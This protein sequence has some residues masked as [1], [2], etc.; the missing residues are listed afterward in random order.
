MPKHPNFPA[1]TA[2]IIHFIF[3]WL[4][5]FTGVWLY[6][7]QTR[8]NHSPKASL[9]VLIGC[10]LG[11]GIGNK[12]L[13]IIEVPQSFTT[14][15]WTALLM[16]QTIVGGLLGGLIGVEIAKKILNIKQSTGDNFVFPLVVAIIIGRMGCFLAGLH[17]GTYGVATTLPW[18]VDFGDGI[19]RHPTQI[20]EQLFIIS[21]MLILW[22]FKPQL[23][24]VSGLQFK[25]FLSGYLLW[26]LSIDA[27]KPIPYDYWGLSGIQWA[28]IIALLI[29]LPVTY[30]AI[31]TIKKSQNDG[32]FHQE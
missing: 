25:L 28:C 15:G 2:H 18:G 30:Q 10:L 22:Y 14:Y 31:R 4:A 21:I 29:Y 7:R 3:E 32:T 11:V 12:L 16:G 13:F 23:S 5:V 8:I 6:H 26:R 9:G 24:A 20:Y 27:I 1:E 17:D 19:T